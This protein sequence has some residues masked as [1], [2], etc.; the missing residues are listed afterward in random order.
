[1]N[2]I[3]KW[4]LFALLIMFIAWVIPGINVAGFISALVVVLII[5]LI[6]TFIRPLVQLISLP[7]N[8]ITLGLFSLIINTLLFLLAAKIAPG[9][10]IEGFWSGFFGALI[11][12][13]FTPL[14]DKIDVKR[15][16][17]M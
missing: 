7:L 4:I 13:L 6:N 10:R 16:K 3:L 11:L 5:G 2:M 8:F 1:M 17:D 12:S 9:F 14:I 15:K